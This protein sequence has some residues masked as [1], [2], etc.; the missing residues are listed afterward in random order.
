MEDELVIFMDEDN[1]DEEIYIC[2]NC[3]EMRFEDELVQLNEPFNSDGVCDYC[4][5]ELDYYD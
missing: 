2:P 4:I 3:K 5:E 1:L